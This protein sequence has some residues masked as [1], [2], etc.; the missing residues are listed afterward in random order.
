[1]NT[2]IE[3]EKFKKNP[4]LSSIQSVIEDG[5]KGNIRIFSKYSRKIISVDMTSDILEI[6]LKEFIEQIETMKALYENEYG[7]IISEDDL[8]TFNFSIKCTNEIIILLRT[9]KIDEILTNENEKIFNECH[10]MLNFC[11]DL[12]SPYTGEANSLEKERNE[13]LEFQRN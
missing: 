8:E 13:E 4:T 10:K 6:P 11:D 2:F 5:L 1:M 7:I 12:F 9:K 3:E